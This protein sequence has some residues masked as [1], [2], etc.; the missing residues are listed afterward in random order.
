MFVNLLT[1]QGFNNAAEGD[2]FSGFEN[3]I[4]G[5]FDDTLIGDHGA[6]R[7]DGAM[8]A[9]TLVGNGGSDTFVF[10]HAPGATSPF[11][12]PNVDT[13]FDFTSFEDK[14]E[15]DESAFGGDFPDI[16]MAFKFHTGTAAHDADDRFIYDQSEGKLYFDPDGTGA[17]AQFL[18]AVFPNHDHIEAGDFYIV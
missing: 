9:D 3:V 17:A 11:G 8:G 14:L 10:S 6:N 13:I 12:G 5:L 15:I 7:L 2:S 4:G 18:F 1:G 16:S